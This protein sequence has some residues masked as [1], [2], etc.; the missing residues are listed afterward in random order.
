MSSTHTVPDMTDT[1][2]YATSGTTTKEITGTPGTKYYIRMCKLFNTT[3][4]NYTGVTEFTFAK[5]TLTGLTETSEGVAH[6]TW[7][8]S[9]DL[10]NGF[11][12]M[13]AIETTEQPSYTYYS[14][15]GTI[16][17]GATTS[18]DFSVV[19]GLTHYFRLCQANA[20][21][22]TDG[23]LVYSDVLSLY[24]PSS[25]VI[26]D[27]ATKVG[28]DVTLD[29]T[30]PT[31][32]PYTFDGYMIFRSDQTTAIA[33]VGSST[34]TYTDTSVPAGTYTYVICASSASVCKGY[35]ENDVTVTIP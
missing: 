11:W 12:W 9:G 6:L 14:A 31:G 24:F 30:G 32:S 19:P 18:G 28:S 2:L 26:T 35:S 23:C 15:R 10:A 27:P 22:P 25:L 8:D 33:T 3:C 21:T 16:A 1:T 7:S 4:I 29:W 5:I 13:D 20:S 17:S 34:L